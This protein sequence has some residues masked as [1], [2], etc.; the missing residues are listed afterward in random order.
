MLRI[1]PLLLL[2]GLLACAQSAHQTGQSIFDDVL[3]RELRSQVDRDVDFTELRA[4]PEQYQD[5]VV[6]LSGIVLQAKRAND[7]TEIEVLQLPADPGEPPTANR[8][9]SQGRFLMVKEGLD[10]A[11]LEAGRPV[12][13]IGQV[14]GKATKL[15]DETEYTYPV[16][17]IKHLV[18][19]Q[20]VG[21]RYAGGYGPYYGGPFY[22]RGFGGYYPY[23]PFYSYGPYGY[24][25][26][27]S[28]YYGG[29]GF[30][31]SSPGFSSPTPDSIPRRFHG[32]DE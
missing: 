14:K 23:D 20:Q 11:T 19:W 18:D 29:F 5:K 25:G 28:P 2:F 6:M 3:P 10:P 22:R 1:A 30:G 21:P 16:L 15:L 31:R 27:F 8:A 32:R 17:E 24:Y 4:A 13:V 12:T 7:R 9:S 26:P